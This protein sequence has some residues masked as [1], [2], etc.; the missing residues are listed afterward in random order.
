M[1]L[2]NTLRRLPQISSLSFICQTPQEDSELGYFGGNVPASVRFLTF[3]NSLSAASI[4]A[5]CTYLRAQN[6]SFVRNK[7]K[8]F[9]E[10][11]DESPHSRS[12]RQGLEGLC[13]SHSNLATEDVSS[14]CGLLKGVHDEDSGR[15]ALTHTDESTQIDVENSDVSRV[16]KLS[17][18]RRLYGLRFLDLSH[19]K[20]SDELCSNLVHASIHSALEGLELKGNYIHR[21]LYLCPVL[22]KYLS[23]PQCQLSH[24]GL[25]AN[26]CINATFRSILDGC[27]HGASL[28][29]L[30]LSNNDLTSSDRNCIRVREFLKV[31]V[32]L[33]TL[34]LSHNRFTYGTLGGISSSA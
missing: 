29:S 13:I 19:N 22:E 14:I 24:L 5:L 11:E 1:T 18:S 17:T 26:G 12:R 28:T 33:R 15:G 25:S 23:S 31:N 3:Q 6:S 27:Q 21:G 16:P 10:I 34:N 32:S 8:T 30:D 2:V 4:D 7:E 20:L 9:A